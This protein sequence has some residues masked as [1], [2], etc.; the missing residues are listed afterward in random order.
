MFLAL[1]LVA[2]LLLQFKVN[3]EITAESLSW[4]LS[5]IVQSLLALVAL[6]GVVVVFKYQSMATREDRLLE[7]LNKDSSDLGKLG[8]DLTSTSG[9]EL[10]SVI[11][12]RVP[13]VLGPEHGFRIVRLHKIKGELESQVFLKKF[14]GQYALKVSVYSFAVTLI[15]LVILAIVPVIVTVPILSLILVYILICLVADIFR[16]VCKI[17]AETLL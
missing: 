10:L 3:F 7:E 4:V 14:L 11:K 13:S 15:C 1:G 2:C 8:A 9:E 6:M 17:L 5:S 12:G 16:L